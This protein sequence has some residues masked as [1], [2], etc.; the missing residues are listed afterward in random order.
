VIKKEAEILEYK[1]LI[2]EIELMGDVKTKVVSVI[3]GASRTICESFRKYLS[4]IPRKHSINE[5]QKT[6]ILDA[7]HIRSAW[8]VALHEPYSNYRMAAT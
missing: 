2:I 3:I 5:P 8:E 7:A 6:A 1:D 4:N